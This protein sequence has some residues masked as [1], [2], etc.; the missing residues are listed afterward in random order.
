[1]GTDSPFGADL[2]AQPHRL[3]EDLRRI[4]READGRDLTLREI[5][6]MM[7]GRGIAAMALFIALPFLLPNPLSFVF[8]VP[9]IILGLRIALD[10]PS[11]LP[12]RVL[13]RKI[14][15]WVL[16]RIV[17]VGLWVF[18]KVERVSKPRW[19]FMHSW[20]GMRRLIGVGVVVSA[21]VMA[22]PAVVPNFVPAAAIILLLLGLIE[23]DGVFV[24][25]GY[26]VML[27]SIGWL[28]ALFAVLEAIVRAVLFRLAG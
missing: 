22:L 8:G 25:L 11:W 9:L 19:V 28:I 21:F 26:V 1:M 13:D 23:E 3:S 6:A 18:S 20:G 14:P 2:I 17:T 27:L 16:V 12:V 5:E 24:A 15:H 7:Q 10:Q 4:L